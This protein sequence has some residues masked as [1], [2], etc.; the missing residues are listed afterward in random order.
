MR[1]DLRIRRCESI[2]S[3]RFRCSMKVRRKSLCQ[4]TTW[5]KDFGALEMRKHSSRHQN[6]E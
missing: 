6:A 2:W 3:T 1:F 5:Y 4:S